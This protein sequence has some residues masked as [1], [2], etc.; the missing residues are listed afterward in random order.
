MALTDIKGGKTV[1]VQYLEVTVSHTHP[2][3]RYY[4]YIFIQMC[5]KAEVTVTV[6]ERDEK[7]P[8]RHCS[9]RLDGKTCERQTLT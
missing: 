9:S 2:A 3:I 6:L 8:K 1:Y 5:D 7:S 4:A